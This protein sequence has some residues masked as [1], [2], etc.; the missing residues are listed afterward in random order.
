MQKKDFYD[1]TDPF[2]R[3]I[4]KNTF[5][6]YVGHIYTNGKVVLD[7]FFENQDTGRVAENQAIYIMDI[8]DFYRLS[9]L[10]KQELIH[11]PL[12]KRIYH[13]GNWQGKIQTVIEDKRKSKTA[14]ELKELI[15]TGNVQK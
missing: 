6:G 13:A 5:E 8:S 3:I 4:G 11:N 9:S 15:K 10:Q 1:R 2:F 7:K 12:C 14:E